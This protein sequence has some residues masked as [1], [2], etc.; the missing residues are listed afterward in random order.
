[1]DFIG[2]YIKDIFVGKV[3]IRKATFLEADQ[4]KDFLTKEIHNG[5]KKFVIDLS[6][7][8]SID[9]IFLG[10]V[11][12]TYKKLI[13]INGNLKLIRPKVNIYSNQNFENS[14]R[15]FETYHSVEDAVNSYKKI[16]VKPTEELIP[17][18]MPL[19]MT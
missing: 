7:C 14:L 2:E 18:R 1:M 17:I 15:I 11:I 10:V 8:G 4:F 12:Q 3:G 6:S 19:A 16:F 5:Y 9:P 13:N